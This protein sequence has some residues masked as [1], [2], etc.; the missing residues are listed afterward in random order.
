MSLIDHSAEIA[1]GSIHVAL[2]DGHGVYRRRLMIALEHDEAIAVVADAAV[3]GALGPVLAE[4]TPHVLIVDLAAPDG[5]PVD[6]IQRLSAA[7]PGTAVLALA[8]PSDDPAPALIAGAAGSLTKTEALR[9]GSEV[10][11]HLAAGH[12]Y[13]DRRAASSLSRLVE[14]HENFP[15]LSK[16]HVEVLHQISAG[17][18]LRELGPFFR[19]STEELERDVL[20]ILDVLRRDRANSV[21]D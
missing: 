11:R 18:T 19:C 7:M 13:V 21:A 3:P 1:S 20:L 12:V 17:R 4:V 8:G 14:R 16:H 10:V 9:R 6:G 2:C 15:G 5:D